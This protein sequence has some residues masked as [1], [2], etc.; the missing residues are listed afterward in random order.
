MLFSESLLRDV[1]L[2]RR[3]HLIGSDATSIQP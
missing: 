1:I 2:R 3:T